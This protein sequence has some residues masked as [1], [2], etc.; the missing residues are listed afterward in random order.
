MTTPFKTWYRLRAARNS[1]EVR[2]YEEIG[3]WGVTAKQFADDLA[4]LGELRSI[5]VRINSPGGD[6]FE[7][8]AMHNTLQRYPARV[9]VHIDGLCASAATVVALAGDETRMVSNGLYMI[10]EP[11]TLTQGNTKDLQRQSDLLDSVAQQIIDL[12]TRKTGLPP[13]DIRQRMQAETWMTAEQALESGFIDVIDEPLRIAARVHDLTRFKNVPSEISMSEPQTPPVTP[14]ASVPPNPA[15]PGTPPVA[16]VPVVPPPPEP[17]PAAEIA[18]AC[19]DAKEPA[20]GVV[21]LKTPHTRE[22]V[23]A[24]IEQAV[25]VRAVCVTAGVPA[26]ADELIA[27]GKTEADAKT[28]TWEHLAARSMRNPVDATPPAQKQAM[29]RTAFLALAPGK[30]REFVLAGGQVTD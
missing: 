5:D 7:A 15:A 19:L 30:Q 25:R 4:A 18:Q 22:Q 8:M 29:T 1:A 11:W 12:Y 13:D 23:Q 9:V 21:L 28:A 24:R 10:H 17:L 6:V 20:L 16:S 3:A 26:L 2:I 14:V 27:A